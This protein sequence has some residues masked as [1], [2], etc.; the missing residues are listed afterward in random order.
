RG[1]VARVAR[2]DI[3][4]GPLEPSVG[5]RDS[6]SLPRRSAR[7]ITAASVS[8]QPTGHVVDIEP[9]S[10]LHP[11]NAGELW[12]YRELLYFLAWRDIKEIG[13]ASCRE[14]VKISVVDVV[15]KK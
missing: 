2:V 10:G 9:S 14:R 12:R 1:A 13:R 8:T 3:R 4:R 11:L 15:L 7:V 6:R 5:P